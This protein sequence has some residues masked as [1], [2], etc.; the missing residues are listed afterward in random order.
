MSEYQTYVDILTRRHSCRAFQSRLVDR[1]VIE[2]IITAAQRVPSWC[3]SQPWQV[4]ITS[5]ETTEQVRASLIHAAQNDPHAPDVEFPTEYT[6]EYKT[7]RSVCGWQLYDAVGVPKGDRDGARI[8]MMENYRLFGAPH[9]ALITAPANLGS[10]GMLDCG[11]F[12]SAFTIA[13]TSLGIGTIAQAAVAG[14]APTLRKL[15]N[16]ADDR[17]ILCGISFGYADTDHPANG[18]RTE[19]APLSEFVTFA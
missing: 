9:L 18:F 19:R 2:Q 15:L 5:G 6:G 4:T 8:Q 13:A 14:Y 3:N 7:R 1:A 12:V 17:L 10:Y 16:I 11:S